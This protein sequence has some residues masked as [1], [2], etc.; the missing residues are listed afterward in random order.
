MPIYYGFSTQEVNQRRTILTNGR[1][2]GPGALNREPQITK[3]FR[4]TD[5]QLVIRDFINSFNIKQ[6]DKVGQ[7]G[8]GTNIWE[9]IF[10]PNITEVTNQI[11]E[12][13][14]RVASQDARI[15]PNTINVYPYDNGVLIQ[16]QMTV[17]PF[18][19]I[20]EFGFYLNKDSQTAQQYI[21]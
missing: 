7:P 17:Q 9:Y 10:E 6:G 15:L 14:R 8:Y 16:I 18:N 12:E 13:I 19:N 2:A 5:E 21:S 4:L 3:K 1:F 11:E 20:I